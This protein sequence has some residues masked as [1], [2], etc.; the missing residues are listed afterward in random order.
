MW[1]KTYMH[2]MT[3]IKDWC[4]SRQ[5]WWG[6]R[7]PAW[8]CDDCDAVMVLRDDPTACTGCGSAK[9]RQDDDVL[10]T[11]F[12]SGLWPFSTLGWPDDEAAKRSGLKTF[13]PNA[14]LVTAA[15]I[16]FFWVARMMMMG[17]HF[18]GKVPFK[19]VYFTPI[20]TDSHGD[21][22]SKTK[23]NVMDP[24]DIVHGATLEAL[25]ER[26]EADHL[27]NSA[28]AAIKKNFGK[29]INPAGADALRFTLAA[30]ALP[31]RYLR[32]SMERI[33]GYRNFVNKLWNAS[34]FALMNL[35][36]FAPDR[37]EKLATSGTPTEEMALEDRWIMSRLQRISAEVDEA[38]EGFRFADAAN[39]LYHFVWGELC[40]WYIEL[41]KPSLYGAGVDETEDGPA[42]RRRFIT[43]GTLA[44]VL[45]L[46]LR[47]LHPFMP[48]VTEE[49]WH[50]LPKPSGLPNSLMIT[51]YPEADQR[52]ID[53]EAEHEMELLQEITVAIRTL[54]ATYSVPPS[55]SVPVEVRAPND[56][57]RD[58]VERHRSLIEN[59]AKVT[60]TVADS[61][62][63]IP[64]SAKS[65]VRADIEVVVP[66]AGL[67][68]VD[69]EKARIAKAL[70]KTE[71]EIAH[72]S[73]KLS[74]P[75]F[76]ERA[77]DDVVDKEKAKL[78]EE[79]KRREALE[80]ALAALG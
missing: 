59:A 14:T 62:E 7:I 2:W 75:S 21:K 15:D 69:E 77:P 12:S 72:V 32:L 13:Y 25:L 41:A 66:L 10:D 52:Y 3:N 43:Q 45:E 60:M 11:W 23:G 8:Y 27:Q 29:G 70:K 76:L 19:T 33:E 40:D 39:T 48:F 78:A 4:I 73:K 35:D 18:M 6:H 31:G 58:I 68:D 49:I 24:L 1:T 65:I 47:L 34:R 57:D 36:N 80:Q 17:I 54:R 79:E 28:V 61:G 9:I 51:V 44:T 50:K 46:T 37:F 42:A 55:W 56:A 22:M 67:V 71:K 53:A 63:H 64:Q 26:A 20:V 5:L 74:N 30:M 16:I 38:L